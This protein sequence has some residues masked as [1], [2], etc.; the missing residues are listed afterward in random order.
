MAKRKEHSLV[1]KRKAEEREE[2]FAHAYIAFKFNGK[3]AAVSI[4]VDPRSAETIASRLLRTVKV[5]SIL[6]EHVAQIVEKHGLTADHVMSEAK[7][8]GFANMLDYISVQSDG[9]AVIDFANVTRD[10]FAAVGEITVDE[11]TEGRGDDSRQVKRTKFKLHDKL[12]ALSLILRYITMG[13]GSSPMDPGGGQPQ[14]NNF[15]FTQNNV[16]LTPQ[17]A[18]GQYQKMLNGG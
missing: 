17:Q 11:Y 5:Q 13:K 14:V 2:M 10:Q 15:N 12:A 7:K 6:T 9:S 8:M 4:G 18:V 1:I 16:T 3:Q